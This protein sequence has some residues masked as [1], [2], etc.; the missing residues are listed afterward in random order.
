MQQQ[1]GVKEQIIEIHG[2]RPFATIPV[3]FVNVG[4]LWLFGHLILILNFRIILVLLRVDQI[5]FGCRNPVKYIAGIIGLVIQ[6]KLPYN[7]FQNAFGIIGVVDGK[8]FRVS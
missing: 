6:L 4:Y 1:I 5:H 8:V 7:G 2:S 3:L